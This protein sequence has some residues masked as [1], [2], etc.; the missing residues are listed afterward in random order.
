MLKYDTIYIF[1]NCTS[2]LASFVYDRFNIGDPLKKKD[3]FVFEI[4]RS[5]HMNV[6]IRNG[7]ILKI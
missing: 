4:L 7:F 2:I 5:E 1:V 6:K 3:V